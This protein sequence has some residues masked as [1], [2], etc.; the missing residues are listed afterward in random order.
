MT[1]TEL[2]ANLRL[3]SIPN[4]GSVTAKKL[5]AHCGSASKIFSSTKAEL[6][7]IDG[8]GTLKLK[9]IFDTAHLDAAEEEL[10]FIEKNNIETLYFTDAAYPDYL[11]HA[12]DA[13]IL[14]FKRGNIDLKNRK[15]ISVVGTRKIT[16]YGTA[17]CEK[18]IADIAPLNPVIVSGF[19][20]GVDIC[21]QKEAVKHGLQTIGCLAHGL[22]QIY[23]KVHSKYTADIEKNGGFLTEF[24][25]TSTPERE[26]FLKRNRIIAGLSEATVVIESAEKGGSLVTADI[27]HSYNRDVFAVPGR[28]EDKYS[29]GC[30]NLIKQQKAHMITSAADVVYLLDWETQKNENQNIQ[31]QLF[32]ELSDLEQ[33][34][35]SYLQ[36]EG[37]QLLDTIALACN[38]PV[39][40]TS[41]TLLN[42]EMK[43]AIRPLPGKLFEAI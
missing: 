6:L 29:L 36:T 38:I 25:S 16:S 19:A 27:A 26:N 3:Q 33:Q 32:V 40:K 13:P 12:I 18:F 4:I 24:W 5:I 28:T 9:N 11:K 20:Y 8:I 42:M 15:I 21:I 39:F 35:H 34:I 1:T 41:S 43:G 31:K 22:N 30:N 7:K 14:L 23:P 10:Q 2:I 17:F 37:K